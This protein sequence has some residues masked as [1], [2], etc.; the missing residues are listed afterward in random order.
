M[1]LIIRRKSSMSEVALC[2]HLM[3]SSAPWNELFFTEEH[4]LE[5][6][7]DPSLDLYIAEFEGGFV[8]FMATRATGM[9]GE[10]LL[11]Y[12]CVKP[13]YRG[14]GIGTSML[15]YVEE[16][17]FPNANNIYLFVS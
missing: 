7:S 17:I 15:E 9:E 8:G 13:Q 10:P 3:A 2:A 16:I 6:L 12:I 11:E 5:N 4:C 14:C 1:N